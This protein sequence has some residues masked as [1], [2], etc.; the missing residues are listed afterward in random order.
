M[1]RRLETVVCGTRSTRQ[2]LSP[3]GKGE[4]EPSDT[5]QAATETR[6]AVVCV[7]TEDEKPWAG[8]TIGESSAELREEPSAGEE[9]K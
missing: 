4:H 5:H 8:F 2:Q 7:Q 3:T 6:D 9:A 1:T